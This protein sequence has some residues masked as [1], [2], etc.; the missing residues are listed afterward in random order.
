[1]CAFARPAPEG[2]RLHVADLDP[3]ATKR[4]LEKAFGRYGPLREIWMARTVP[5]F[6]FVVY[7]YKDDAEEACEGAD[8]VEIC[9]RR[10]RV[11]FAK[12]RARQRREGS[13]GGGGG[14]HQVGRERSLYYY[15]NC[16][17][18]Y[19]HLSPPFRAIRDRV[20]AVAALTPTCGATSAGTRVTSPGTAEA[21]S[22]GTSGRPA[23]MGTTATATGA[24]GATGEEAGDAD[25]ATTG[26][27][28]TTSG[29][30]KTSDL[31]WCGV[32]RT[33]SL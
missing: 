8:G 18:S 20:A 22:T 17:I 11:T 12:P 4:D 30:D 3:H 15:C 26:G 9:Q 5:C 33:K 7:R 13:S 6:A 32:R 23:R 31:P 28:T 14:G 2:Y 1:M 10:I 25:T 21:T 24:E 27:T 29:Q 19:G 16:V